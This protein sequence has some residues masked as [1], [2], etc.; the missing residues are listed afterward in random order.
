M[1]N[2]ISI[3]FESSS[4]ADLK[5]V[6]A[7]V[8][9]QHP[10]TRILCMAY[11]TRDDVPPAI[12]YPG[13]PFPPV[14]RL[15]VETS[16]FAAFNSFFEYCVWTNVGVPQH[17]FPP[18]ALDQ[19]DNTQAN[20]VQ[21]NLPGSL[22]GVAKALGLPERKDDEG[23][24]LMRRLMKGAVATDAEMHRLGMYCI[25]DVVVERAAGKRL[26]ELS[27]VESRIYQLDQQINL[28]G[29]PVDVEFARLAAK[30]A[31]EYQKAKAV[32]AQAQFGIN[33]TQVGQIMQRLQSMG[34]PLEDLRGDTLDDI[35][36]T[37]MAKFFPAD[38]IALLTLRREAAAA[39]P[40]KY[41]AMLRA[42]SADG[43]IRG[44]FQ[45]CGAQQTGRWS[46]RVVQLHNLMRPT[47]KFDRILEAMQALRDSDG[48]W[49]SLTPFGPILEVLG[50]MLRPTIVA[51]GGMTKS[52]FA[53]IEARV[54]AWLAD[55]TKV[56]DIFNANGD[57]YSMTASGI[58]GRTITK[59]KD[60]DERMVGKVSDLSMGYGGGKGAFIMM[61]RN[62]GI[63][64]TEERAEEIKTAW[65]EDHPGTVGL[66][67]ACD[68]A[69]KSALS[70]TNKTFYAANGKLEFTATNGTLWC[71]LPSGRALCWHGA[72]IVLKT[73]PWDED[74]PLLK[75]TKRPVIAFQRPMGASMVTDYTRGAVIVEN[76][77][78]AVSRDVLADAMLRA[79]H[80]PLFGHVHD[81]VWAEGN[82]VDELH[83]HMLVVPD[84][85]AGLP[86]H[87]E[88]D[89]S[90]RYK[91]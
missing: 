26:G 5:E 28:R 82:H 88:T 74:K 31:A 45:Y 3:D 20:A 41:A 85:A 73:P 71:K 22:D 89:Y 87:A 4:D 55:E 76:V 66:W 81:E 21:R 37:P 1:N 11:Q 48:Y 75:Q 51:P 19:W 70:N 6:G 36:D 63:N 68:T 40:K 46:G 54:L 77:C 84:W 10:S 9:S 47:M 32:E 86:L 80:L 67:S 14:L 61:G 33:P 16:R 39:A 91:K 25:Q 49:G 43:R 59:E 79:Q 2:N 12:W 60:P 52:D 62:Y 35:L 8:Y 58:Y 27:P 34:V 7:Y 44:M 69:A 72:R 57:V 24:R 17:G 18:L 53:Q 90:L 23:S 15:H 50:N 56:I 83:Q 78:Q 38:A 42:V 29:V 30:A 13:M 65:R 64:V